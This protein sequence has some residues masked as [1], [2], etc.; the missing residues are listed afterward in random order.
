MVLRNAASNMNPFVAFTDVVYLRSELIFKQVLRWIDNAVRF[1][2]WYRSPLK[3]STK[4]K[5]GWLSPLIHPSFLF[6]MN[7]VQALCNVTPIHFPIISSLLF[8]WRNVFK[9][10]LHYILW[11]ECIENTATFC[12][13]LYLKAW[14]FSLFLRTNISALFPARWLP[15]KF[16][17]T[18]ENF[19]S[20]S[21]VSFWWHCHVGS[22][23]INNLGNKFL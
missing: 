11:R 12:Y 13:F 17:I 23:W 22:I 16:S 15:R 14:K 21:L 19:I 6:L 1:K 18:P 10:S 2:Y 5:F 8:F 20:S 7:D 4:P 3:I 9:F